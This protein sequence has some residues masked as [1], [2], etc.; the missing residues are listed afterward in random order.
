[1][2]LPCLTLVLAQSAQYLAAARS[3]ILD[4][5][6]SDYLLLA[7]AKGLRD[8]EVRRRHAIPNALLPVT[9]M[10]FTHLGYVVS[11]VVTVETVFSWPGLGSLIYEATAI[12]DL[13][14][15]QGTFLL[16]A[17]TVVV[18]NVLSDGAYRL[19]DPRLRSR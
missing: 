4:Q 11:G 13:P 1:M 15:L 9:A 16:V 8:A 6:G 18:T 7:R 2:V 12:P 14:L 17:G 19:I 10:T 3:S 5:A